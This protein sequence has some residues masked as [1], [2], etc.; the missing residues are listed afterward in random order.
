MSKEIWV[1]AYEEVYDDPANEGKSEDE[2]VA[3]TNERAA[4]KEARMADEAYERYQEAMLRRDS[5]V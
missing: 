5:G 2:L 1:R 4:D 3:L